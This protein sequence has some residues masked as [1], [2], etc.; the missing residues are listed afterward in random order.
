MREGVWG[1]EGRK[2]RTQLKQTKQDA[3]QPHCRTLTTWPVLSCSQSPTS[4]GWI[5]KRKSTDS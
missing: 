4:K 3:P 2:M 5:T 1:C